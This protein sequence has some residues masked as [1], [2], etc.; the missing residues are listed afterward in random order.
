MNANLRSRIARTAGFTLVEIMIGL[1]IGVIGIVIIMQVYAVSENYKRTATS[2]TDAQINGAVALYLL[3]REIRLA[4][5]GMNSLVP[6]GCTTVRVWTTS[7]GSGADLPMVPLAINPAGVPA[8]DANT[9][10]LLVSYGTSSNFVGGVQADQ[11]SAAADFSITYNRDGFRNGDL[12]VAMQPG[13]GPGGTNSC[14]M[15]ELTAVPSAAGNCGSASA[16]LGH[17][18]ASYKNS[19][20]GCVATTPKHNAAGAMT[21]SA[22]GTVP[23][24][25]HITG[26]QL[27]DLGS[28]VIKVYAV[29]GG[30]LTYCEWLKKDCTVVAN[31]DVAVNDIASLRAAYG[32][33]FDG[34]PL[35]ITA[36]GDGKVD[37]WSRAA[38]TTSNQ[39]SRVL[40]AALQVTARSGLKE[41]PSNGGTVCDATLSAS[42]PD[43]GQTKDWY[44]PFKSMES[45]AGTLA[46]GA[47]DLSGTSADWKCYRYKLFQTAVPL[48]NM[49]WRP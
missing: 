35:P 49:I 41:K 39:V 9:D 43:R 14:V 46:T 29:R 5:Y 40:A 47:I 12:V 20:N 15:Y 31:Y 21:D 27:F 30:N 3:E 38:L 32:E 23:A 7:T 18:T 22:G 17:G 19:N 6:L 10:V 1:L 24:L 26:G 48:R 4:G 11:A 25:N 34:A 2:G 16:T 36:M 45:P 42:R 33:D 37:Q 44:E 8:G 28:F 13:A